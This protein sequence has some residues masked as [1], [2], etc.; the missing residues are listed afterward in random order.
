MKFIIRI[1]RKIKRIENS[2]PFNFSFRVKETSLNRMFIILFLAKVVVLFIFQIKRGNT[3]EDRSKMIQANLKKE[4]A[5]SKTENKF[6][7]I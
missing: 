7:I 5:G 1:K 6:V 4:V 3:A 2:W